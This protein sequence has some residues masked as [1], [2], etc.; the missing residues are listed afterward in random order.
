MHTET[1]ANNEVQGCKVRE[2]AKDLPAND[3]MYDV[4]WI[5]KIRRFSVATRLIMNHV[6]TIFCDRV[7]T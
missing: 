2:S 3:T 5:M 6:L 4:R 1:M 7:K